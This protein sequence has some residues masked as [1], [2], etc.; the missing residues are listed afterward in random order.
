MLLASCKS[1]LDEP[2]YLR[3][4]ELRQHL[5][6]IDPVDLTQV[7]DAV[8]APD[9]TQPLQP[10][11]LPPA[12]SKLSLEQ[13]RVMVLANNLELQVELLNPA[14]AAQSV[15][16]QEARFEALFFANS[17]YARTD[18]PTA[19]TLS[20]S[21]TK[22][23]QNDMGVDL[24][25]Q[26]GG[27]LRFNLAANQFKTDNVFS[28]LNPSY[29]TDASISLS[30]NLLRGA[31]IRANTHAIRLAQYQHQQANAATHLAVIRILANTDRAYWRLQAARQVLQVRQAEHELAVVQL[32]KARRMVDS[33]ELAEIE[34][35]RAESGVAERLSAI[36]TAENTVRL[37]QRALKRM[38]ND[39]GLPMDGPTA[40][41][42]TT[43]ANPVR[44]DFAP[45]KLVSMAMDGRMELLELELQLAQQA[46]TLHFERNAALPLAL[47]DYTY[48]FNGLGRTYG[49][50]FDMLSDRDFAD[51]RLGLRVEVPLGNEAARS[52][53]RRAIL[54]RMQTLSSVEQR[55]ALIE[56]E[57]LNAADQ[58]A[59]SW[60]QIL[61][62]R[63]SA[64]LAHR[65]FMAEQ[66]QF[67][68]GLR[69]ST[70]VLDAQARYSDAQ[71]A[72]VRAIAEYQIAQIDL[73]YATGSILGADQVRWESRGIEQ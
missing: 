36:I 49:N 17:S 58:L 12:E 1:P 7:A 3:S 52:R 57:V 4:E 72:E 59:S 71:A 23:V 29:A 51:Y 42:P 50:S 20:G 41:I 35:T 5:Q 65:T 69:T 54:H 8:H 73:A 18:T 60:Q 13:C 19:T 64:I 45:E 48:N 34:I 6:Q 31:G 25:L 16:E 43:D 27:N 56:E 33:G 46:S 55:K 30:Q 62:A 63:Q 32:E 26:T 37:E 53:V 28:T 10:A 38:L 68:Q 67:E 11:A 14:I 47:L 24:P 39:A 61:A 44:Y 70:D 15:S 21:Q 2:A 9:E 22:A 66:R 40:V